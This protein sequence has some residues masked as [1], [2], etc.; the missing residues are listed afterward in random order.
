MAPLGAGGMPGVTVDSELDLERVVTIMALE[1]SDRA[2]MGLIHPQ[3]MGN[4]T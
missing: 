3:V 1:D 4:I 2:L